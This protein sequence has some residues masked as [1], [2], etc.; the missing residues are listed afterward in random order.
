MAYIYGQLSTAAS[1]VQAFEHQRLVGEIKKP[2]KLV[3]RAVEQF[4]AHQVWHTIGRP[5]HIADAH[6]PE[7]QPL[8]GVIDVCVDDSD[9]EAS[10]VAHAQLDGCLMRQE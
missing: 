1:C 10:V 7:R 3:D 5:A 4:D 8:P 2:K 6:V 9:A